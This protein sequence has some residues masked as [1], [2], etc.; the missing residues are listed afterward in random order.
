MTTRSFSLVPFEKNFLL[1]EI[2]LQGTV[3]RR[4]GGWLVCYDIEGDIGDLSLPE[5]VPGPTRRD[6]LWKTTCLELF[7]ALQGEPLYW[8][9]NFSPRGDWNAYRFD[10]YRKPGG[11]L[12]PLD[13]PTIQCRKT[14]TSF[15]LEAECR[16]EA[17]PPG[18]AVE[19]GLGAVIESRTGGL[20]YWALLHPGPKPD[21]HR[22]EGFVL[23]L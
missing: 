18:R 20:S 2:R 15:H 10:A 19:I 17:L 8:E 9:F 11:E 12:P 1:P 16:M 7:V 5:P 14:T 6:E 23:S 3:T 21:F 22:R 13:P 4:E